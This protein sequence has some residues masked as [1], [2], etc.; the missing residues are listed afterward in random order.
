MADSNPLS[1]TPAA[2]RERRDGWT[3]QRQSLFI[4]A[5]ARG[6]SIA[7]AAA[8]LGMSRKSAYALRE[9]PE[10]Q[11]FARAWDAALEQARQRR[12]AS[13]PLSLA[14]R[15]LH[16]EWHPRLYR[17]RLIGWVHRPAGTLAIGLLNRLDRQETA[18]A[19]KGQIPP[20]SSEGNRSG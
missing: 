17:G 16:G 10:A 20:A 6:D 13:R 8:D 4:L 12:Q 11:S 18:R 3:A 5:L 19:R 2:L 9:R 14:E 15:A 7:K 1:F